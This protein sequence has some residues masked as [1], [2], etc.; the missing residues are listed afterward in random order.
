MGMLLGLAILFVLVASL[1]V[2]PALLIAVERR[3]APRPS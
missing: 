1:L 3:A 2:L